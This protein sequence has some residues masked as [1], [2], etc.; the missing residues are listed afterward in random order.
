M[1][2]NICRR[3]YKADFG[4]SSSDTEG[5]SQWFHIIRNARSNWLAVGSFRDIYK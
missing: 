4:Y 3:I 5:D 1:I 2:I